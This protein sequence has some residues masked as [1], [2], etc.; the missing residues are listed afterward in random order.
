MND[1]MTKYIGRIH[2]ET[3]NLFANNCIHKSLK[4]FKKAKE[5]GIKAELVVCISSVPGI[6][7]LIP[8]FGL[9][10]HFFVLLEGQKVDVALS[11]EQ[12]EK[13]WKNSDLKIFLPL[14]IARQ[15]GF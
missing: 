9:W 4:I 10:P 7:G 6:R 5:L 13:F 1:E 15:K 12:E 8:L 14:K 3:Y 11:P 2:N